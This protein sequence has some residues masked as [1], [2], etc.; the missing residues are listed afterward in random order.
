MK[1]GEARVVSDKLAAFE[2]EALTTVSCIIGDL[3]VVVE[4][5]AFCRVE[6]VLVGAASAFACRTC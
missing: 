4:C 2:D 1:V 5:N 6:G 3:D